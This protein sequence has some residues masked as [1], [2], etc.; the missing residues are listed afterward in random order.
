MGME[1]RPRKK[2]GR[3]KKQRHEEKDMRKVSFM[4]S[5]IVGNSFRFKDDGDYLRVIPIKSYIRTYR[6]NFAARR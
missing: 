3:R 6:H 4:I 2:R 5:G 1:K